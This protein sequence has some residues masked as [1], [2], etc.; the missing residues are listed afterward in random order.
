MEA[1]KEVV[2]PT[3]KNV[4][5]DILINLG[6]ETI[7]TSLTSHTAQ[8][9]IS[10]PSTAVSVS[11]YGWTY[12][13]TDNLTLEG[14]LLLAI[15]FFVLFTSDLSNPYLGKTSIVSSFTIVVLILPWL[16]WFVHSCLY[17]NNYLLSVQFLNFV[18]VVVDTLGT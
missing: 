16:L 14:H 2:D 11:P 3:F 7:D 8:I 1:S 9:H 12:N 15:I 5:E 6:G 13:S 4:I 18:I 10:D 17:L